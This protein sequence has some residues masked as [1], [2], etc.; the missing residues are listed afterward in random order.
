MVEYK[1]KK[2]LSADYMHF[3]LFKEDCVTDLM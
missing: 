1:G 3:L 2:G